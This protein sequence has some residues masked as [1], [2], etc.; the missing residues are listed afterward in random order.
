MVES[1]RQPIRLRLAF[2]TVFWSTAAVTFLVRQLALLSFIRRRLRWLRHS[3][4]VVFFLYQSPKSLY[5]AFA[6]GALVAVIADL[7]VRFV[8]APQLARWFEPRP[9]DPAFATPVEF[10]LGAREWV[11]SRSPARQQNG[12]GWAAGEL[13]LSNQRLFFLPHAWDREPWSVPL[14]DLQGFRVEPA[15]K[16]VLGLVRG[17]PDRLVLD[18]VEGE[19]AFAVADPLQILDWFHD[20]K[21]ARYLHLA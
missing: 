10:Q 13:I 9:A 5:L 3:K 12:R 8:L 20:H 17:L 7:L 11:V 16:L 14:V 2:G 4:R 18:T 1:N 21:A 15:P 6:I 19:S